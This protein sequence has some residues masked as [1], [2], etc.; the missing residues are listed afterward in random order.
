MSIFHTTANGGTGTTWRQLG[1]TDYGA[2][3]VTTVVDVSAALLMSH[4]VCEAS[5]PAYAAT[6]PQIVVF[7]S[8]AVSCP[9]S[10]PPCAH[11]AS[12]V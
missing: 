5:W 12:S 8:L 4:L 6:L 7:S 1:D 3:G 2:I 9:I 10:H 11:I